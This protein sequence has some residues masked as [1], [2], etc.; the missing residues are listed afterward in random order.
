MKSHMKLEKHL[1]VFFWIFPILEVHVL[2][3][4]LYQN[5]PH[6]K[7]F[8]FSGLS[9]AMS[10]YSDPSA[11]CSFFAL[12]GKIHRR[13]RL[14]PAF[15]RVGEHT[16]CHLFLTFWSGPVWSALELIPLLWLKQEDTVAILWRNFGVLFGSLQG[17]LPKAERLDC[18]SSTYLNKSCGNLGRRGTKTVS[19]LRI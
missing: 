4:I 9:E 3:R 10:N 8:S 14:L 2:L 18:H 5:I 6:F 12:G 11:T 16:L 1:K 7:P 19:A 15:L 17:R 13:Q